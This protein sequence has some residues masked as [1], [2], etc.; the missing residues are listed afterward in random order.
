M[1]LV[2]ISICFYHQLSALKLNFLENVFW[3]EDFHKLRVTLLL[4]LVSKYALNFTLLTW[5]QETPA[6][7]C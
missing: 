3:D 2:H 6:S 7:Y 4:G 1:D 5:Q